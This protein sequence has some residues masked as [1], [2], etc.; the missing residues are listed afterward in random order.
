MARK[1]K[2]KLNVT[3]SKHLLKYLVTISHLVSNVTFPSL[4]KIFEQIFATIL[5]IVEMYF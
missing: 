5:A 3:R 1:L 2:I 4:G